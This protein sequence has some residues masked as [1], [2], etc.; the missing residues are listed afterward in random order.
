MA[1]VRMKHL[2]SINYC[3]KGVVKFFEKNNLDL[4]DFCKN[5]IDESKLLPLNDAMA[6]KAVEIARKEK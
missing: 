6:N 1:V 3:A 2:R 5:G 4:K